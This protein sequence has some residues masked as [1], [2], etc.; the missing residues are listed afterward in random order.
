MA[1]FSERLERASQATQSLV[2]VGLDPDPTRMPVAD[3]FEFN[4]AIVDAT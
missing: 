4:R 2:C 3:V 1:Q